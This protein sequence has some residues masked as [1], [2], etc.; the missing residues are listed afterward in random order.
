MAGAIGSTGLARAGRVDRMRTVTTRSSRVRWLRQAV[1]PFFQRLRTASRIVRGKHR[2]NH[3][4]R[5]RVQLGQLLAV[6]FDNQVRYGP[7]RGLKLPERTRWGAG[8]DVGSMLL[9]LYEQELLQ[10][11]QALPGTRSVLVDLG[12]ANG[13]FGLGVLVNRLFE[14]SYCYERSPASREILREV[15]EDNGLAQ[16]VSILGAAEPGFWRSISHPL[17]DC[18]VMVDIEG[19]EF[20]LLD[21]AFFAAFRQSIV[22]VELHEWFYADGAERLARLRERASRTFAITELTTSARDLSVF[23]ELSR[24]SDD[25]R[26]ILCSEGRGRRMT[27]WRLEPHP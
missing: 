22:F 11:L 10:A 26:W 12:A 1:R 7:F 3:V 14:Y 17:S 9:G 23:P 13:Y 2:P 24:L 15:A 27:W 21:E 16:R 4:L 8:G 25:D 6:E 18:V 5:R 19:G 20:D